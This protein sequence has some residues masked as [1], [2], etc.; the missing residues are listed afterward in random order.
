[1]LPGGR[2]RTR[3]HLAMLF[4]IFVVLVALYFYLRRRKGKKGAT[5]EVAR[6]TTPAIDAWIAQALEIELAEGA[7]GM[8]ASTPE[9]RKKLAE[10]LKGNPDPEVVEA[11]ES[12]VK[13]VELE[14]VKYA[15][16]TDAEVT[17]RVRYTDGSAGTAS[18]RFSWEDVPP[19][20]REDFAKR[21][22]S[23]VFNSYVF[24]WARMRAL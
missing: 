18:K 13:L 6:D 8:R 22:S 23:R 11:V 10:S 2:P 3:Y 4:A 16:E 7:L 20:I 15:H 9:E 5:H 1:M 17:L 14:Y 21:S 12:K 24:P 19:A